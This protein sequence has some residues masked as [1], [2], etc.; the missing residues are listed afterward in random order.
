MSTNIYIC[1]LQIKGSERK[2]E[3]LYSSSPKHIN[4]VKFLAELS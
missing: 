1:N 4:I 2:Q 3:Y